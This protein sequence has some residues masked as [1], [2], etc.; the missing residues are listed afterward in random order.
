MRSNYQQLTQH[1]MRANAVRRT[2]HARIFCERSL[3]GAEMHSRGCMFKMGLSCAHLHRRVSRS[4]NH[5]S[6]ESSDSSGVGNQ[7]VLDNRVVWAVDTV[8]WQCHDYYDT[9]K[10]PMDLGTL[11]QNLEACTYAEA[12]A[13]VLSRPTIVAHATAS[14]ERPCA[15]A[16]S[17]RICSWCGPTLF[18]TTGE[19]Q[20]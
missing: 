6:L 11:R 16:G 18:C 2:R 4:S 5:Q 1:Q 7:P 8:K 13:C 3:T 9:I 15:T 20:L 12:D 17:V 14:V 19:S 10:T